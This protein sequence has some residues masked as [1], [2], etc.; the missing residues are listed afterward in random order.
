MWCEPVNCSIGRST[1]PGRPPPRTN[2]VHSWSPRH[3]ITTGCPNQ[4]SSSRSN[5]GVTVWRVACWVMVRW[6][7]PYHDACSPGWHLRHVAE[8]TCPDSSTSNGR[9][10]RRGG[11]AG[12]Y[13][14]QTV[15]EPT[16][17]RPATAAATRGRA[18][19]EQSRSSGASAAAPR[20]TTIQTNAEILAADR[21]TAHQGL[22][23]AILTTGRRARS[24]RQ[25]NAGSRT[26]SRIRSRSVTRPAATN[27]STARS[28]RKRSTGRR[29]RPTA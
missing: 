9:S 14:V 17:T 11:S 15:T 21:H 5:C 27:S 16:P 7:D 20:M 25:R 23:A 28:T 3:S 6:N 12:A 8:P 2:L 18:P 10:S 19:L 13:I 1:G 26:T 29:S 24:G 22:A 4:S